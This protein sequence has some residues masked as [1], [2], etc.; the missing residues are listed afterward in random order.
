MAETS[1]DAVLSDPAYRAAAVDLLAAIAYGELSAFERLVDDAKLAPRLS[2]KISLERM[3]AAQF[4]VVDP[5]LNR[6]AELGAEPTE[7]LAPFK[8]AFDDFHQETA[9]SDFV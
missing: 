8:T 4:A 3:A 5:L 6:I 2:D 1:D 7:A 9:P